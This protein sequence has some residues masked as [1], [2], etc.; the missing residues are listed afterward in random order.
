MIVFMYIG[1]TVIFTVA[2]FSYSS[3]MPISLYQGG[4][5][6]LFTPAGWLI[7]WTVC[8]IKQNWADSKDMWGHV[9]MMGQRLRRCNL[10]SAQI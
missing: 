5:P 4:Y 3:M 1:R 6:H 10:Y 2:G 8:S 7:G 9:G